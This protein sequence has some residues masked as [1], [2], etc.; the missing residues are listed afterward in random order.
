VTVV[1]FGED[2][3]EEIEGDDEPELEL[4]L[5]MLMSNKETG[6]LSVWPSVA[7]GLLLQA[8]LIVSRTLFWGRL[9]RP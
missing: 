2:M 8:A 7:L 6:K 4:E 1:A 5:E 9:K 3:E